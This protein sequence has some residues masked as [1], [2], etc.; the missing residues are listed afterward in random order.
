MSAHVAEKGGGFLRSTWRFLVRFLGN[1]CRRI[2]IFCRYTLICLQQ[3][4]L[5]RA[6]AR[7][8]RRVHLALEEG[9]VNP[10]LT[11]PVKDAVQRAR[12]LKAAKDRQYAAIAALRENIRRTWE[13]AA[14]RPAEEA[15]PREPVAEPGA[16]VEPG[17]TAEP[18][19]PAEPPAAE[20]EKPPEEAGT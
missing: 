9:E 2:L 12:R 19:E 10:M 15:E 7:L 1:V 20:P 6:W 14:P 11:E 3:Q 17:E 16:A 4:R 5:R 13:E 18:G 8:G